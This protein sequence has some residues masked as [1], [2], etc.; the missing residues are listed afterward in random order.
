MRA[1]RISLCLFLLVMLVVVTGA[2]GVARVK[3]EMTKEL[4]A[5]P[6]AAGAAAEQLSLSV[7][8]WQS[9]RWWL[10]L[11]LHRSQ[12]RAVEERLLELF[13]CA[14]M[15]DEAQTEYTLARQALTLAVEEMR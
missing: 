9:A 14:A 11:C 10:R 2:I 15:G 7:E 13:L 3:G 8:R 5:L 1:M 6:E 4:E 12:F